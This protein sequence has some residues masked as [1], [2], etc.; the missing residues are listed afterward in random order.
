MFVGALKID[1]LVLESRSLKEKRMIVR[2]IK[3]R[4]RQRLGLTVVEVGALELWQRAEL[5]VAVTAQER[6]QVQALLDDV[7][8]SVTTT[9]GVELLHASRDIAPFIGEALDPPPPR[10]PDDSSW[11]PEEWRA[12]LD[13]ESP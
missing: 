1:L 3:D 13:E 12:S 8:R 2:R 4:A 10:A 7:W 11:I 9:E 5:G 6:G